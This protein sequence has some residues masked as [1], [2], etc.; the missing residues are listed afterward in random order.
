MRL[1]G[2]V[3]LW[4]PPPAPPAP[5]DVEPVDEVDDVV[6]DVVSSPPPEQAVRRPRAN[7]VARFEG[8]I[9]VSIAG[10]VTE[11]LKATLIAP[12]GGEERRRRGQPGRGP[13]RLVTVSGLS[14][15]DAIPLTPGG[16]S[17]E[18]TAISRGTL[19]A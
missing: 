5:P 19:L 9:L 2:L 15:S 18:S 1:S 16:G 10:W 7:S 12:L 8:R 6:P 3:G 11:Q 14:A 13:G 17:A 4:R